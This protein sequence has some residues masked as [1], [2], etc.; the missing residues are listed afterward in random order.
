MTRACRWVRPA[1]PLLSALLTRPT[2]VSAIKKAGYEGR[3]RIGMDVAASEFFKAE[4]KKYDL[5]FKAKVSTLAFVCGFS[6][7]R[8]SE[9]RRL[10]LR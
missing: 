1:P 7:A 5:N 6:L 9:Q 8:D 2:V 10:C 4:V 3:V